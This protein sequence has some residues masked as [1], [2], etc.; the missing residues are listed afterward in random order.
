MGYR[1]LYGLF[2]VLS[3]LPFSVL[4]VIADGFYLIVYHLVG[5]RRRVVRRNLTL[6]F[7]EMSL[8]EIKKTEK[9][10]Y[11]WLCDY[12]M[13]TVKLLSISDRQLAK[14][15]EFRG[16]EQIEQCFDKGQAC[17]AMLGHYC[18]WEYLSATGIAMTRWERAVMGLIYHPLRN[19][20]FDRL[21]IAIRE[22]HGGT[23]I[24]KKDIL[25]RLVEYRRSG[26]MS[27]FGYIADQSPKWENIHLFLPFMHQD[28]PVFTGAERIIRKMNNAVFYVHMERPSRGKYVCTFELMTDRP[29]EMEEYELT[30]DF[31]VRLER[32]IQE[33]PAF[34]L[35]T[36]DR[37][38]RTR[39]VY[40]RK[41]AAGEIRG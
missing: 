3:L 19:N 21:F 40:D 18:N 13:E 6:S 28:T 1:L 41:V 20:V 7:P 17:A 24:P 16:A 36:H 38:K 15:L 22:K 26:S 4:Y 12:F 14:H 33:Q 25:R 37:W 39:E 9:A 2:Y 35:W 27:L 8:N 34:Y 10:F 31:F 30:K 5:Y 29:Q 11:H 23:C 32:N